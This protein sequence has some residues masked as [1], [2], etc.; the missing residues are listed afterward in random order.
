MALTLLVSAELCLMKTQQQVIKDQQQTSLLTG[1]PSQWIT[2]SGATMQY[3]DGSVSITL[4]STALMPP[5]TRNMSPLCS[6]R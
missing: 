2:V 6:G 5:R 1:S 4:N 3:G